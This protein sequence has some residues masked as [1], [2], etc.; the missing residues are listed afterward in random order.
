MQHLDMTDLT[1]DILTMRTS[2][3]QL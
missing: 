1:P 3:H 2:L